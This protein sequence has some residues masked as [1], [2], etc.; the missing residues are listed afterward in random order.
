MEK[1]F[2]ARESKSFENQIKRE[3]DL[4]K[5]IDS[6]DDMY[7][8]P[9]M[10]IEQLKLRMF[11]DRL[12]VITMA[13]KIDVPQTNKNKQLLEDILSYLKGESIQVNEEMVN[14]YE[15]RIESL[16]IH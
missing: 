15:E 11:F 8:N 7:M 9:R 14:N 4:Q 5:E 10:T 6:R 3:N 13:K 16:K 1:D 12:K 2:D